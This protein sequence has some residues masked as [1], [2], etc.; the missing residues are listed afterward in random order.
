M[1]WE[2][3]SFDRVM[4]MHF[5]ATDDV[6]HQLYIEQHRTKYWQWLKSDHWRE[7]CCSPLLALAANRY[8]PAFSHA[9]VPMLCRYEPWQ[10]E[11]PDPTPPL[12][13]EETPLT[14]VD[15]PQ[16]LQQMVEVLKGCKHIALDLEHHSYR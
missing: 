6:L 4:R 2:A 3:L 12:S 13:L 14:W 7:S 10:L 5:S 16:Q 15:T 1:S 9:C 8:K 11:A